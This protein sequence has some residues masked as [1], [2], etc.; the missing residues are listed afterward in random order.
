M[1]SVPSHRQLLSGNNLKLFILVAVLFISSSCEFFTKAQDAPSVRKAKEEEKMTPLQGTLVYDPIKGEW[2]RVTGEAVTEKMDTIFWNTIPE[3]QFS[4]I[5]SVATSGGGIVDG[6]EE[7]TISVDEFGSEIKP[8]YNVV[9]MLPFLTNQYDPLSAQFNSLSKWSLDYLCGAKMALKKLEAEEVDLKVSLIDTR[10]QP[11]EVQKILASNNDLKN[12]DLIIGPYRRDNI[13]LVA[14]FAKRNKVT[15]V[16]P[17]SA[18]SNLSEDNPYYLQVSPNL[19]SHCKA[20]TYYARKKFKPQQMVILYQDNSAKRQTAQYFQEANVLYNNGQPT[21]RITEYSVPDGRIPTA[22]ELN[23]SQFTSSGDSIAFIIPAWSRGDENF[24]FVALSQISLEKE[25]FQYVEVYGMPQWQQFDKI[26]LDY[27]EKLNVH[28][29]SNLYI[30]ERAQEIKN[31]RRDY[32]DQYGLIAPFEAYLSYDVM[33]FVG[34]MLEK[35]GNKFQYHIEKENPQYLHTRFE[36]ERVVERGPTGFEQP[37]IDQFENKF[38]NILRF[39]NY[40]FQ[41][42]N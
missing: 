33:L 29:S 31:F 24:V 1:I 13:K 15:M 41:K 7:A 20:I 5:V 8:S 32:Y 4:P 21:D 39:Q 18:S 2:I 37:V 22:E 12:A 34:R 36:F 19:K 40:R 10:A 38:V 17:Y 23:I 16:S 28:I 42:V 27:F 35:Y 25:P 14:E 11:G 3:E 26:D 30:D 9:M 6:N